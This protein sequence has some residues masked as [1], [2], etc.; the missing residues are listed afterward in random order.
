MFTWSLTFVNLFILLSNRQWEPERKEFFYN[1]NFLHHIY[2]LK[3]D[4][5]LRV[6]ILQR[7]FQ[8]I[9]SK[10]I[11][12]FR[13]RFLFF[14]CV[15]L[16]ARF[17]FSLFNHK[18]N[19]GK[20]YATSLPPTYFRVYLGLVFHVQTSK[21]WV[22]LAASHW[23]K[24]PMGYVAVGFKLGPRLAILVPRSLD[25]VLFCLWS[26]LLVRLLG[27]WSGRLFLRLS[28]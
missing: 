26:S 1:S 11:F 12:E 28:I 19:L 3:V 8:S 24:G 23:C 7:S 21:F 20:V 25:L 5:V 15:R 17:Y 16:A 10:R 27:P 2:F 6:W 4:L 18:P 13:F 14:S 9:H 22:C